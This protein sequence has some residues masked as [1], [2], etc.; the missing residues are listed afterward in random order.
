MTRPLRFADP[1]RTL[2]ARLVPLTVAKYGLDF[3]MAQSPEWLADREVML[4]EKP[5]IDASVAFLSSLWDVSDDPETAG[6]LT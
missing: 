6:V 2:V 3:V 5:L 1:K 4:F